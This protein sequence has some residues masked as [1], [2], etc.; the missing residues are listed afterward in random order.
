MTSTV[1]SVLHAYADCATHMLYSTPRSALRT[2][3]IPD[4]H[5]AP[6]LLAPRRWQGGAMSR[7]APGPSTEK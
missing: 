3:A 5:G 7:E 6:P 1:R 2:G 4:V